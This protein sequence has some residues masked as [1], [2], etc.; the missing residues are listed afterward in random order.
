MMQNG[1][2]TDKEMLITFTCLLYCLVPV[3]WGK[4]FGLCFHVVVV[5]SLKVFKVRLDK[6][7]SNLL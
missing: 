6:A 2:P 3:S 5:S 4:Q 1:L 7:L